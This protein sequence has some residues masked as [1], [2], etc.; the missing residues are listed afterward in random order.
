L[1]CYDQATLSETSRHSFQGG[2]ITDVF[3]LSRDRCLVVTGQGAHTIDMKRSRIKTGLPVAVKEA[4][5]ELSYCAESRSTGLT[6]AGFSD[7]TLAL[8]EQRS[9]KVVF[10][11]NADNGPVSGFALNLSMA[12][13]VVVSATGGL[14]LFDLSSGDVFERFTGHSDC[15]EGVKITEDGRYLITRTSSGEFR[16][17][18]LSWTLE[19]AT[20]S[21]PVSWM[22]GGALGR[23]GKLFKMS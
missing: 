2:L 9:G 17:W 1:V 4:P 19:Q 5:G 16:L 22:P 21:P 7:G 20:G 23:L 18:E 11:I 12:V 15:I 10:A 6:Y 3:F 13:G 8:A 14:T